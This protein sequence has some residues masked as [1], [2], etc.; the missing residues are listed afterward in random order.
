MRNRED[1]KRI[2]AVRRLRETREKLSARK[3]AVAD[4]AVREAEG[5]LRAAEDEV[6]RLTEALARGMAQGIEAPEIALF[7]GAWVTLRARR[8]AD[9]KDLSLK[10]GLLRAAGEAYRGDRIDRK[11]AETWE[12]N[13]ARA[14]RAEEERKQAASVD[15]IVV[16]RHGW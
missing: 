15:E 5:R 12:A 10:E 2:A 7:H 11:K 13:T 3:V 6:R 4:A 9:E 16:V 14:I 1:L 8:A